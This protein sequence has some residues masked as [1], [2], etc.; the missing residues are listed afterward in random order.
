MVERF[1]AK[2][3][4]ESV[5]FAI[6]DQAIKTRYTEKNIYHTREDGTSRLCNA[7]KETIHHVVS[8]YTKYANTVCIRRHNN[9][10]KYIDN[11]ICEA[12]GMTSNHNRL[13]KITKSKF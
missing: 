8:G 7:Y 13:L 12:N 9:V 4:T 2:R 5:V 6:Q 10:A 3:N 1:Y 11:K